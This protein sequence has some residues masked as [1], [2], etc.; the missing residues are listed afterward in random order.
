MF[1]EEC[2]AEVLA[3]GMSFFSRL[4]LYTPGTL[5]VEDDSVEDIDELVWL[6]TMLSFT[7][8][9]GGTSEREDEEEEQD[10]EE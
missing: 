3:A 2:A 8:A 9:L 7:V 1:E 5:R 10:E 4:F 6:C